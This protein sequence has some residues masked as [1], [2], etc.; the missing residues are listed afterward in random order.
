MLNP[1]RNPSKE[2][3]AKKEAEK[4]ALEES[5]RSTTEIARQILASSDGKKYREKIKID[6]KTLTETLLKVCADDPIKDAYFMRACLNKIS[7]HYDLLKDIEKDA[8]NI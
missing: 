7:V 3:L 1:F 5:L 6:L 8:E 4:S 2:E